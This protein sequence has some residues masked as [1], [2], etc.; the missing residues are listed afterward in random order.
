MKKY[1]VLIIND[2]EFEIDKK[3]LIKK[4]NL[5]LD[6]IQLMPRVFLIESTSSMRRLNSRFAGVIGANRF[7]INEANLHE[8]KGR[9][10]QAVWDWIKSKR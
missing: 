8:M 6:W 5:C 2:D 7:V 3:I 10:Q 4:L 9:L 1:Y